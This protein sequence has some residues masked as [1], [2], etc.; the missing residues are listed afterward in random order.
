M[1]IRTLTL[2]RHS[3]R[4]PEVH[5]GIECSSAVVGPNGWGEYVHDGGIPCGMATMS[6]PIASIVLL[7]LRFQPFRV[8][9][10]HE[11]V[12]IVW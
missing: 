10:Q 6:F 12:L 8:I 2:S 5:R 9:G 1:I 4:R 7:N 3:N 11:D